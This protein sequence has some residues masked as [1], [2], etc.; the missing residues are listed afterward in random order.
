MSRHLQSTSS[1]SSG[2]TRPRSAERSAEDKEHDGSGGAPS[3]AEYFA[4]DAS[5]YDGDPSPISSPERG[6]TRGLMASQLRGAV[7]RLKIELPPSV[8]RRFLDD[9]KSSLAELRDVEA[10]RSVA[11][12]AEVIVRVCKANPVQAFYYCVDIPDSSPEGFLDLKRR[13]NL[14]FHLEGMRIMHMLSDEDRQKLVDTPLADVLEE[15]KKRDAR[16][17]ILSALRER[18]PDE[19]AMEILQDPACQSR[20]S[21]GGEETA[22]AGKLLE[23]WNERGQVAAR[24]QRLELAFDDYDMQLRDSCPFCNAYIEGKVDA[25]VDDVIGISVIG[26]RLNGRRKE[27][28]KYL[29]ACEEEL[30]NGLHRS[31]VPLKEAV[32]RAMRCVKRLDRARGER[33]TSAALLAHAMR[34]SNYLPFSVMFLRKEI[35]GNES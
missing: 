30:R 18:V 28:G 7:K 22:L 2:R 27:F 13:V 10:L 32:H 9:G 6:M 24:R 5:E 35:A 12:R 16:L 15:F 21:I 3:D 8:V 11:E 29:P 1:R 31:A 26:S 33:Q 19:V 25:D 23:F 14:A 20:V 4:D 17:L 34:V